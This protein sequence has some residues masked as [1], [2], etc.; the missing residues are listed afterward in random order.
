MRTNHN[1]LKT[2]VAVLTAVTCMATSLAGM[3]ASAVNYTTTGTD[4]SMAAEAT[5]SKGVYVV[6]DTDMNIVLPYMA[7]ENSL[8]K[9][10]YEDTNVKDNK[11]SIGF[12]LLPQRT[13]QST[14]QRSQTVLSAT[15]FWVRCTRQAT[16]LCLLRFMAVLRLAVC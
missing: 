7:F 3:T 4:K 12:L 11:F 8:T 9:Y 6:K 1:K 15:P 13:S 16:L 2:C 5:L 10:S 14:Q